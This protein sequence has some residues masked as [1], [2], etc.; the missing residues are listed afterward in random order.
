MTRILHDF[1]LCNNNITIKL[2]ILFKES[3]VCYNN[4]LTVNIVVY[5]IINGVGSILYIIIR[6]FKRKK[7]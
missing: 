4:V 1:A 6:I 3:L 5:V 2:R 7:K